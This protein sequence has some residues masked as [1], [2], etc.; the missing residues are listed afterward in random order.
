LVAALDN[1]PAQNYQEAAEAKFID[2]A[3]RL[4]RERDSARELLREIRDNEVNPQDEADK[5]LRDG[6]CSELSKCREA[7][8]GRTVS[9]ERCNEMAAQ[10]V[11]LREALTEFTSWGSGMDDASFHDVPRLLAI[12]RGALYDS[13]P[14]AVVPLAEITRLKQELQEARTDANQL[15]GAIELAIPHLPSSAGSAK[16]RHFAVKHGNTSD[17]FAFKAILTAFERHEALARQ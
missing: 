15:A 4:E 14:P 11:A 1:L 10:I 12:A 17:E 16:A 5:F 13:K 9:C 8:S 2:F 3:E 6:V 7:L